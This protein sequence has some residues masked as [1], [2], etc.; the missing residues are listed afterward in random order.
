MKKIN[1]VYSVFLFLFMLAGSLYA[2]GHDSLLYDGA[3]TPTGIT[4]D[5]YVRVIYTKG[6]TNGTYHVTK[7]YQICGK[8]E[9]SKETETGKLSPMNEL[10]LGEEISTGEDGSLEMQFFDGSRL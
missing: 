7:T 1:S 3:T 10:K 9:T 4:E 2:G 8:T 6:T 5:C